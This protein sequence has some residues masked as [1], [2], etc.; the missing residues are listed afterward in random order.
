MLPWI[1]FSKCRIGL[2]I[3]VLAG[4]GD[5]RPDRVPVSGVVH[6]DGTVVTPEAGEELFGFVRFYPLDGGRMAQARLDENG[7][8]TLGNY[9]TT[10][11]C[12]RGEFAVEISVTS[13]KDERFRFRV[14]SRYANR[15]TSDVRVTISDRMDS[16]ILETHWLPEDEK[17][18]KKT[19]R[20][21]NDTI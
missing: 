18:R 6:V 17:E 16:L 13:R 2:L 7:S 9:E 3:I 12:P 19:Y 14:P 1:D 15:E 21:E 11:G 5:G 8:F 10:D 20:I 4:C